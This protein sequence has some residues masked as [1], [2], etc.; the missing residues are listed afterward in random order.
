MGAH[1][2]E[3]VMWWPALAL[4]WLVAVPHSGLL[5]VTRIGAGLVVLAWIR[6]RVLVVEGVQVEKVPF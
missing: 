6:G 3:V 4:M 5:A 1:L 2:V